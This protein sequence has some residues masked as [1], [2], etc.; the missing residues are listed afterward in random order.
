M[1]KADGKAELISHLPHL[2]KVKVKSKINKQNLLKP[3]NHLKLNKNHMYLLH[4]V[5]IIVVVL[6]EVEHT[7]T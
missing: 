4:G 3:N 2:S 7:L 6:Q 1:E 5:R